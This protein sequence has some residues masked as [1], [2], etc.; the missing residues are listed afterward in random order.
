MVERVGEQMTQWFRIDKGDGSISRV[1]LLR[2]MEA[3]EK[4]YKKPSEVIKVGRF[5]NTFAI[6]SDQANLTPDEQKSISHD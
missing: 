4:W 6:Y 5:A 2:V 1:T 3:A